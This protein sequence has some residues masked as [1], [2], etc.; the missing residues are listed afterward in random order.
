MAEE[1][2]AQAPTIDNESN[3]LVLP[4]MMD[5]VRV[6]VLGLL[7]GLLV[8]VIGWLLQKYFI[9][10]VFCHETA[11]LGVCAAND[12]T[13]Y[14]VGTIIMTVIAVAVLANWQIFRPLLIAVAAASA[15]WGLQRYLGETLAKAGWEYYLS[16]AVIY[17]LAFISFYWLLRLKNFA[18]S[19]ALCVVA[20]VLMRWVLLV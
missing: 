10:P 5:L 14:Y 3:A 9:T 18:L 1:T 12:L 17:G 19:V 16:S 6:G 2:I 15:L 7:I 13:T 20:V 8:P 11:T 4:E